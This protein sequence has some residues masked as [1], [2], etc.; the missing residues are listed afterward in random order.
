MGD[1]GSN[2]QNVDHLDPNHNGIA[3]EEGEPG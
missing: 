1:G 2:R 3:C